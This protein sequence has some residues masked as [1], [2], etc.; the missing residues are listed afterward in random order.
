MQWREARDQTLEVWRG[1]RDSLGSEE[2]AADRV[3]LLTEINAVVD[4]CVKAREDSGGAFLERCNHCLAFQQFGGC[5]GISAEMS[6]AVVA[7][8]EERLRGLIDQFIAQLETMEL[9]PEEGAAA[10]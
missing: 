5:K 6:E 4:L 1:I 9:P 10:P 8:E 3:E 2:E 7:G